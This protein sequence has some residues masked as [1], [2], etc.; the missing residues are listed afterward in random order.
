MRGSVEDFVFRDH[1]SMDEGMFIDSSMS[2]A[3]AR[4]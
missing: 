4:I 1:D 3:E 2:G